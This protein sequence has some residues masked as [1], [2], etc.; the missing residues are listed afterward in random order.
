MVRYV[1]IIE[2]QVRAYIRQPKLNYRE[3]KRKERE[4]SSKKGELSEGEE[5][6]SLKPGKSPRERS[7]DEVREDKLSFRHTEYAVLDM[8]QVGAL[9]SPT[10]PTG[11]PDTWDQCTLNRLL[12]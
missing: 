11:K 2:I 1:S 9:R 8:D 12:V 6:I 7:R 3:E 4:N 5:E 10:R